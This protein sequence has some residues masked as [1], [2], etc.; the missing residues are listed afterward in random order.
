MGS[1]MTQNGMTHPLHQNSKPSTT[2]CRRIFDLFYPLLDRDCQLNLHPKTQ[3]TNKKST[4]T[5][6]LKRFT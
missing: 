6:Y 5:F 1:E 4:S 3:N 2:E